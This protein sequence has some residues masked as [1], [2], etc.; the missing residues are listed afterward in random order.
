[1]LY[2]IKTQG[3]RIK[4]ARKEKGLTQ[5][6]LAKMAGMKGHQII[7][8]YEKGKRGKRGNENPS[9]SLL[10]K[11]A[12]ITGVSVDWI[13]TGRDEKNNIDSNN[14]SAIDRFSPI[15]GWD[16]IML[17]KGKRNNMNL[18]NCELV[19]LFS[20]ESRDC[21]GLRIRDDSMVSE[22]VY[23]D[24]FIEG[25][26]I[27]VDPN[28]EHSEGDYIIASEN[29]SE[30]PK[31]RKLSSFD[32]RLILKALNNKYRDIY[33]NRESIVYGVVIAKHKKIKRNN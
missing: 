15:I 27:I 10:L 2:N 29:V 12:D 4:Y 14:Y 3:D 7:Q 28:L 18:D 31:L 33:L 1:M 13:L 26:I 17:W 8:N 32:G 19:P 6:M 20:E 11:I 24:S 9:L 23:S 30:I 21:F 25:E 22:D 16:E 5:I